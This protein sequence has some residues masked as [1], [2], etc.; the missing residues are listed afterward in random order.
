MRSIGL[1]FDLLLKGHHFCLSVEKR[2]M[3]ISAQI[4]SSRDLFLEFVA[5]AGATRDA[6]TAISWVQVSKICIS[7][8]LYVSAHPPK[9]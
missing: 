2:A 1:I 4:E 9:Q 6:R 8:G 7:S 3:A 5:Y